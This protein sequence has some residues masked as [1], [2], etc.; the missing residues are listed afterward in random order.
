MVI[1]GTDFELGDRAGI[2]GGF[3]VALDYVMSR[4]LDDTTSKS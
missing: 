1:G 3:A 4:I 2:Y